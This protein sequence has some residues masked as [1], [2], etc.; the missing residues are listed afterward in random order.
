MIALPA[1]LPFI[2]VSQ[3]NLALCEPTWLTGTLKDAELATW[4]MVANLVMN[5]DEFLN[6]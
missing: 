2:R 1:E 5:L 6:K 3:E 4:T